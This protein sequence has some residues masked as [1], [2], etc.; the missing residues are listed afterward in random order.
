MT[1]NPTPNY[2]TIP[3]TT[4]SPT[5]TQTLTSLHQQHHRPWREFLSP[6]SFSIPTTYTLIT[7]RIRRNLNYFRYN[8]TLITLTIIFLSL[9]Y[10][11][12]SI[13]VFLILFL[14]WLLLYFSRSSPLVVLGRPIDD[15]I[16]LV[17]L[18]V[19]TVVA[20]VLTNVGVNVLVA[21]LI[22][23]VVV[24]VH[25]ALRG[26]DDLFLGAD[27]FEDDVD[28][29]GLVDVVQGHPLRPTYARVV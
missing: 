22:S 2:G 8:Y 15:R 18:F 27:D 23:V 24:S 26:I 5:T 6:P 9:L 1:T 10:H 7:S 14:L 13:I 4:P 12:I 28:G 20:L 21:L 19:V 17:L 25:A 3:T 29:S 11:P 16:V